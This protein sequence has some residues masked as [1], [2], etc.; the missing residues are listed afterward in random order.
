MEAFISQM[1][2]AN[3]R[4]ED[5]QANWDGYRP[6]LLSKNDFA[7][8]SQLWLYFHHYFSVWHPL[9]PFLEGAS[10]RDSFSLLCLNVRNGMEVFDGMTAEDALVLSVTLEAV[11]QIGGQRQT[12]RVQP[13]R[14]VVTHLI[15]AACE[16]FRLDYI[17]AI[18]ALFAVELSLWFA[19]RF[20]PASHIS[21]LLS[22]KSPI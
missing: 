1:E 15:L 20:R 22:S 7:D 4:R 16:A 2:E 14:A 6:H 19:R 17:S 13:A 5:D 10:L 12:R 8:E 11:F 21:G 18:R 9:F 3:P